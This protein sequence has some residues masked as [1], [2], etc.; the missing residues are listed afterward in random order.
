MF[1]LPSIFVSTY[2]FKSFL[3][4]ICS[5]GEGEGGGEG[6]GADPGDLESMFVFPHRLIPVMNSTVTTTHETDSPW[7]QKC[8]I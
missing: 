8:P 4:I 1:C 2:L 3:Y 7:N 5:N 6:G